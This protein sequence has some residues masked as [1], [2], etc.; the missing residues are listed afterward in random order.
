MKNNRGVSALMLAVKTGKLEFLKRFDELP[1]G[2]DGDKIEWSTNALLAL[3]KEHR[4]SEVVQFLKKRIERE[5][6]RKLAS[7]N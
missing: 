3:A 7:S 1:D 5:K 2:E 4:Q 6:A